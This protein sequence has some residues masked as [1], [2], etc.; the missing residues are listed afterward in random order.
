M[1][2]LHGAEIKTSYEIS[3]IRF[4][5]R[6]QMKYFKTTIIVFN[7]AENTG[8]IKES[9]KLFVVKI[10]YGMALVNSDQR[11]PVKFAGVCR[12]AFRSQITA[13]SHFI[14]LFHK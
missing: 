11:T 13:F 6:I 3:F 8:Q 14:K 1:E 2:F 4:L 5:I 10:V 9:L 7:P 12:S